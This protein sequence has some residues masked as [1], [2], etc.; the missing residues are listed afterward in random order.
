[1][2]PAEAAKLA[3]VNYETARTWKALNESHKEHITSFLDEN[4]SAVIQ[5]AVE[6]LTRSF[7]GLEIKKSRVAEF[8]KEECNLSIKVARNSKTTLEARAKW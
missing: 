3:N 4:P 2:K 8:M 6:D 1:M 7:E 5:D